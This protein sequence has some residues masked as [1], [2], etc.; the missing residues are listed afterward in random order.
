MIVKA[1]RVDPKCSYF[2]IITEHLATLSHDKQQK[3]QEILVEKNGENE[4]PIPHIW[5]PTFIAIVNAFACQDYRLIAGVKDVKPVSA[6]TAKQIKEYIQDYGEILVELP[7]ETW[8]SSV[9][10]YYGDYWNVL[11]DLYTQAEGRSDLVLKAE[12]KENGSG[13]IFDIELVYVP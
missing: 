7:D 9:S 5:R 10:M 1:A 3:M 13:Y 2:Q 4:L 8:D 11:I 6:E 12:V